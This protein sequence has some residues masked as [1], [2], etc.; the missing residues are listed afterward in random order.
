VLYGAFGVAILLLIWWGVAEK[1]GPLRMP[2]PWRV[3]VAIKANWQSIPAMQYIAMQAGG[4]G[5]ALAYTVVSVLVTVAI[6]AALGVLVGV[7]L[8]HVT[9]LR[10]T[11]TPALVVLGSTPLL[12]LLPFLVQWFGTGR[13]VRSGIVII[14]TFVVMATVCLRSTT[15]AVGSYG[16]YARSLGAKP[17][18][19]MWHV[20]FP[21]L[22]P[23]LLAGVRVS[24]SAAWSLQAVAEIVGGKNGTGRII[25]TMAHLANTTVILAVV[26]CLCV[27]AVVVDGL[28]TLLARRS[29]AWR[30]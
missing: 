3:L 12:I 11:V 25:S 19:E 26:V 4:L 15:Q 18:F 21:A 20:V 13:F 1:L 22:F 7:A 8:P 16:Q 17:A 14:F 29:V 24:L 27:T 5:E 30:D 23:D 9:L 6:G 10:L 2:D 28:F